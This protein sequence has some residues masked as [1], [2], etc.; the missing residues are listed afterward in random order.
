MFSYQACPQVRRWLE[1]LFEQVEHE[2][3]WV[4]RYAGPGEQEICLIVHY[5]DSADRHAEASQMLEGH[6][7]SLE[8]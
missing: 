5:L 3:Y 6:Q 7:L 2:A 8:W 4:M 1:K